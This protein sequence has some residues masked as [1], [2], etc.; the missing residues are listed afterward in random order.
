MILAIIEKLEAAVAAIAY[1]VYARF[2]TTDYLEDFEDDFEDDSLMTT[3][4][5]DEMQKTTK[6]K[7]CV[8]R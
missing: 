6:N 3:S 4:S 7:R 2:F 1:G 5:R 8:M